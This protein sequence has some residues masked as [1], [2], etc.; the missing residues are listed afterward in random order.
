MRNQKVITVF[1]IAIHWSLS[2]AP[3]FQTIPPHHSRLSHP[4][5]SLQNPAYYYPPTFILVFLVA[6]SLLALSPKPY[7]HSS[8]H[9]CY[10]TCPS[11]SPW[12]DHCML[13]EEYKLWSSS[14]CPALRSKFS[15][16]R[17]SLNQQY[18]KWR[19]QNG[20]CN[21]RSEPQFEI[22]VSVVTSVMCLRL[23]TIIYKLWGFGQLS[24]FS[25]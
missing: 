10:M 14:H 8:L 20:Y 13:G 15:A 19:I 21:E 18:N 12:L 2:R 4:I 17:A 3:S 11:H 1:A 22:P 16:K 5:V 24:E 9:A 6:S 23:V 7:T 25:E